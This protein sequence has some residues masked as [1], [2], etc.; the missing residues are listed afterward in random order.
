MAFLDCT[1]ASSRLEFV[2]GRSRTSRDQPGAQKRTWLEEM[3]RPAPDRLFHPTEVGLPYMPAPKQY[4]P[5]LGEYGSRI[6]GRYPMFGD[7]LRSC[8]LSP[9]MGKL[10]NFRTLVIDNGDE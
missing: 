1:D 3:S 9:K 7:D 4:A 6:G 5:V 10:Y 8:T 2:I